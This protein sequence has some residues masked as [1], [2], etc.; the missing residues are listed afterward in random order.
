MYGEKIGVA[1]VLKEGYSQID[2]K[3]YCH[4]NIPSYRVP[5]NLYCIEKIPKNERGK[6]DRILLKSMLNI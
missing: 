2:F 4:D 3:S 5:Q 6:I 1:L